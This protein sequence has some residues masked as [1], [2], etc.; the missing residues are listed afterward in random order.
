MVIVK[1]NMEYSCL[2]F[3][4]FLKTQRELL[5]KFIGQDKYNFKQSKALGES[6]MLIEE[7]DALIWSDFNPR[8]DF[9]I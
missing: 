7:E 8:L 6:A 4:T 2:E 5:G 3:F 9:L 1:N